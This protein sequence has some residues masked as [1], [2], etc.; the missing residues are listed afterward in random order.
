ML[1]SVDLRNNGG[2]AQGVKT[3]RPL[4]IWPQTSSESSAETTARIKLDKLRAVDFLKQE[5]SCDVEFSTLQLREFSALAIGDEEKAA[6]SP[7]PDFPEGYTYCHRSERPVR[8]TTLQ[9][10]L[11]CVNG[12][13]GPIVPLK[14][15][16]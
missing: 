15:D 11:T 12:S 10:G 2:F 7:C 9:Q 16:G 4:I 5:F 8:R 14:Q 3:A 6:L 1:P 13:K